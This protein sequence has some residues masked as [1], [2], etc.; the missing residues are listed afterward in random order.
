MRHN[1]I[2]AALIAFAV[3]AGAATTARA[4]VPDM[5]PVQG[6]LTDDVGT[7]LDGDQTIQFRIY[8]VETGGTALFDETQV[9]AIDDGNFT[10]YLGQIQSL[11]LS[12]LRGNIY[13]GVKVGSDPEMTPRLQFGTVPFAAYA[14]ECASVPPGAIMFFELAQCPDGW[15]AFAGLD[16]RA[17]VGVGSGTLSGTRGTALGNQGAR[18]INQVPSHSH[19]VN[20]PASF[21]DYSGSMSMS[22][23]TTSSGT[24][25]HNVWVEPF[26]G[27]GTY[28]AAGVVNNSSGGQ[29]SSELI[30]SGSGGHSHN[31]SVTG[32]N[33]RH[34]IDIGNFNTA[35]AGAASVDVTMPYI[36]LRACIKN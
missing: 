25:G 7:P 15:S 12:A 35:T 17:P 28:G 36:Q 5:L 13:L 10:A 32:A 9:V 18:T 1:H 33:H 21:S 20:P 26:G 22:G 30:S 8:D 6:V 2:L 27:Y 4:Q 31:V 11:D 34:S 14:Q 3:S 16:G 29:Y 23:S 24:H 19:G